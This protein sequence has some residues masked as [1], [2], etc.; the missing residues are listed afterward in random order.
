MK[1]KKEEKKKKKKKKRKRK[2]KKT[3]FCYFNVSQPIIIDDDCE[4][5]K[6]NQPENR[7]NMDLFLL[8]ENE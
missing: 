8:S 7:W 2:E 5:L 6:L 1:K 4:Q 3:Y